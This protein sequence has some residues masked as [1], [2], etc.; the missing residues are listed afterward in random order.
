MSDNNNS[1][2]SDVLDSVTTDTDSVVEVVEIVKRPFT[3][4]LK[5]EKND[6]ELLRHQLGLW[7]SSGGERSPNAIKYQDRI[8]I[9]VELQVQAK[10]KDEADAKLKR[11]EAAKKGVATKAA[12]KKEALRPALA[13]S[14]LNKEEL[15]N[16]KM[17]SDLLDQYITYEGERCPDAVKLRNRIVTVEAARDKDW[18]VAIDMNNAWDEAAEERAKKSPMLFSQLHGIE[19]ADREKMTALRDQWITFAGDRDKEAIKFIDHL[20]K[21]DEEAATAKIGDIVDGI[22]KIF[23]DEKKHDYYVKE[24]KRLEKMIE[25]LQF[26]YVVE[27]DNHYYWLQDANR[28]STGI[29]KTAANTKLQISGG[30]QQAAY[31]LVMERLSRNRDNIECTFKPSGDSAFNMMSMDHWLK[32]KYSKDDS[33]S[34]YHPVFDML[35]DTLSSGREK[36]RDHLEMVILWKWLHPEEYRLPAIMFYGESS[37]GAGKNTL[38]STILQTIYGREQAAVLKYKDISGD[39]NESQMGKVV[40]L[41]DEMQPDKKSTELMKQDNGNSTISINGKGMKVVIVDN[42]CHRWYT[43]NDGVTSMLLSGAIQDRR[44]SPIEIRWGL[45]ETIRKMAESGLIN[46]SEFG[47]PI[48]WFFQHEHNLSDSNQVALWLGA[49]LN[50]HKAT[51]DAH[52]SAKTYPRCLHGEDYLNVLAKQGGPFTDAIERVFNDEFTNITL[53]EAHAY[54]LEVIAD[55][56]QNVQSRFTKNFKSFCDD[57]DVYIGRNKLP[58]ERKRVKMDDGKQKES[59]IVFCNRGSY[60]YVDKALYEK[61]DLGDRI[62]VST[63]DWNLARN[64]GARLAAGKGIMLGEA[65]HYNV[66]RLTRLVD[67]MKM[68]E[69]DMENDSE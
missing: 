5:K 54:Y 55:D 38:F 32:P 7:V 27:M 64:W 40:L 17:L 26:H 50:K 66:K 2:A 52:E 23:E 47:E 39:F 30:V 18:V 37:G 10:A 68:M 56:Y 45:E 43:C 57:V 3:Q 35:F 69:N 63:I 24:V 33:E 12:K 8:D 4:L 9:V 46:I 58:V 59:W 34:G 6:L 65:K 53:K 51:I 28:W 31:D 42:T 49:M 20:N 29:N 61:N 36:Y 41:L 16:I 14:Q 15:D 22:E 62:S 25:A 21:L 60:Q 67:V 1:G 19:K 44:F 11:S 13:Y 48:E